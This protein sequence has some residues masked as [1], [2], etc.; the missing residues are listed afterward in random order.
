MYVTK[1]LNAQAVSSTT[2]VSSTYIPRERP[3]QF[4]LTVVKHSGTTAVT[5][6]FV[7]VIEGSFDNTNWFNI[8][9]IKNTDAEYADALPAAERNFAWTKVVPLAPYMRVRL[10]EGSGYNFTVWIAE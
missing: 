5:S 6:S 4:G 9:V 1:L 10:D 2:V 8:E 7:G 3:D